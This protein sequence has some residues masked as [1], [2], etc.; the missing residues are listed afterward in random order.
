M[1]PTD[2]AAK[3]AKL[4]QERDT[5]ITALYDSTREPH[6]LAAEC[7]EAIAA[8]R[9]FD[10]TPVYP[11]VTFVDPKTRTQNYVTYRDGVFYVGGGSRPWHT[12]VELAYHFVEVEKLDE[13]VTRLL[14]L[15]GEAASVE[16]YA[17]VNVYAD[18]GHSFFRDVNAGRERGIGSGAVETIPLYRHPPTPAAYQKVG[19][20][21]L[22]TAD[23]FRQ[24]WYSGVN[25]FT[26]EWCEGQAVSAAAHHNGGTAHVLYAGEA[27][28]P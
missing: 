28:T 1:N 3:R 15:K 25:G 21:L 18:G 6:Q 23:G 14:A 17:L 19:A 11:S 27:L 4:V 9:A 5:A 12:A 7:A 13:F 8:L 2:H 20:C 10:A 24:S 16:P 22:T 26:Q